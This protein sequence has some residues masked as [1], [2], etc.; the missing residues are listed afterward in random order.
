[1]EWTDLVVEVRAEDAQAAAD[2]ALLFSD[3]GLY[4]EDYRDLEEQVWQMA[5]VD[6]IEQKLLEK[7]R[8][9]VRVHLYLSPEEDAQK[10]N[11]QLQAH[12]FEAGVQATVLVD[13]VQ[14]EAWESAWKRY[15]HPVEIGE[16]LAVVPSWEQYDGGR[17]ILWLDPGMAFGTGTHETTVLCLEELDARVRGGERVLD[18]GTG[19]GILAIAALLLGAESVLAVDI[20]P[21]SV[22][23]ATE[24]ARRNGVQDHLTVRAGDLAAN[25]LG[26]YDIITSNIVADAICRLAPQVPVL[27]ADDGVF[28][29]SGI[30]DERAEEVTDALREAGLVL[31]EIRRKNGWVA[32][33][34]AR[35]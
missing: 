26:I 29:A 24:N 5:H 18:V 10:I 30:I 3:G 8:E 16:R 14:Q 35:A 21:M 32:L 23:V 13:T 11:R 6:L 7:S 9:I 12:L 25:A 1:M 34:A 33:V 27:L 17:A 31:R 15:Y 28:V 22:R 4:I 20:D 19:S 2:I